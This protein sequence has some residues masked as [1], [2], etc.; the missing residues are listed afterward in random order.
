MRHSREP[1]GRTEALLEKV[2]FRRRRIACGDEQA[3]IPE[4]S[5]SDQA[6]LREQRC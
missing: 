6:S 2:G 1:L 5:V 4:G 3:Q